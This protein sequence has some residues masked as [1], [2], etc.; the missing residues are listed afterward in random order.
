MLESDCL[1]GKA[2]VRWSKQDLLK[3]KSCLPHLN[4]CSLPTRQKL[5]EGQT[6]LRVNNPFL[7]N[8]AASVDGPYTYFDVNIA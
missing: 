8:Y 1:P 3:Y 6:S 2:E 7:Y 5:D 4:E